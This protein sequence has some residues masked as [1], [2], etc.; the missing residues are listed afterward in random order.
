[1]QFPPSSVG[2]QL[3]PFPSWRR[4]A[5]TGT[6][7]ALNKR[8]HARAASVCQG[9]KSVVLQ[10]RIASL[11]AGCGYVQTALG[12]TLDADETQGAVETPE[13]VD[14]HRQPGAERLPG[15][16][17][18]DPRPGASRR[19]GGTATRRIRWPSGSPPGGRWRSA[20]WCRSSLHQLINPLFADFIAGAG[21]TYSAAGYDMVHLRRARARRG[22]GLPRAGARSAGSTASSCTRPRLIDPRI[23]LLNELGLPFLVHGR[24][25][26]PRRLLLAR[27]QQPPRLPAGDRVPG[28]IS[29]TGGSGC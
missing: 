27:H 25:S 13:S 3:R 1:M 12:R 26:R 17:R 5:R 10:N 14:H 6:Q 11:R 19:R 20:M 4:S 9:G 21:E 18:R 15:G 23:D 28:S 16:Q 7:S 24:D 22:R 2:R 29:A 8:E